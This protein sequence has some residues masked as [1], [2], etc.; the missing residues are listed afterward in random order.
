MPGGGGKISDRD[1]NRLM[2]RA[3]ELVSD[4]NLSTPMIVAKLAKEFAHLKIGNRTFRNYCQR[5]SRCVLASTDSVIAGI[6]VAAQR[7]RFLAIVNSE[8]D[9]QYSQRM[10]FNY[11]VL[12]Q[13]GL[14]GALA[15]TKSDVNHTGG[16]TV[17][18]SDT[19]LLADPVVRQ[20]I[21]EL[22]TEQAGPLGG[23]DV[24]APE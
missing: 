15:P 9:E 17:N 2:N 3:C 14:M 19:D 20:R 10:R 11:E 22:K 7:A 16:V 23:H 21:L 8:T 4:P 12:L 5:A 1:T 13:K 6:E 18:S 24:K